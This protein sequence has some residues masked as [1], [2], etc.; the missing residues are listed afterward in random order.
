[1]PVI[2][3]EL[4]RGDPTGRACMEYWYEPQELRRKLWLPPGVPMD[5]RP[6]SL[7]PGLHPTHI[8][9]HALDNQSRTSTAS[10]QLPSGPAHSSSIEEV[11]VHLDLVRQIAFA[12]LMFTDGHTITDQRAL[13]PFGRDCPDRTK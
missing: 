9:I 3:I 12:T 4:S 7:P 10:W 6:D 5:R 2:E 11:S 8:H 13:D 1:M